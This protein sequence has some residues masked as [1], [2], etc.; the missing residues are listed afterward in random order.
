[1]TFQKYKESLLKLAFF[2]MS[3]LLLFPSNI[4]PLVI[5]VFAIVM[6]GFIYFEKLKFDVKYFTING[7]IYLLL[8]LSLVYTDDI[9]YSFKKFESMSSL[10]IFPFLFSFLS[11]F[12]LKI[13][14]NINRFLFY[15]ILSVAL[16]NITF[17]L[18]I[19][20]GGDATFKN[21][22]RHYVFLIDNGLG[23]YNIHPIY[24]SMHLC[25]AIIFCMYLITKKTS[26]KL[27]SP[28]ILILGILFFFLFL[29][30]KKGPIISLALVTVVYF[31]IKTK[32]KHKVFF[33][34]SMIVFFSLIFSSQTS[35]DHFYEILNVK[36]I[37]E[38]EMSSSNI[39]YTI[40]KC[41][42]NLFKKEPL[43]GYGVGDSNNELIKS[44]K[45]VSSKLFYDKYNTHNQYLSFLLRVGLIGLIFILASF[46]F[47]FRKEIKN[48][49]YLFLMVFCFYLLEMFTENIL[50][51]QDGVIFYSFFVALLQGY[52]K[53]EIEV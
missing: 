32:M 25:I 6:I 45:D 43:L 4:K 52:N 29:L 26:V 9:A 34:L 8:I 18:M 2:L 14:K 42:F 35:R 24:M 53:S 51:R 31:F 28:L 22:M 39:R 20:L 49:N 46:F 17:F 3:I 5:G 15:F 10:F 11:K 44:Y 19:W 30:S 50:E 47:L 48:S 21:V 33:L 12:P 1:M 41:S 13:F 36:D 38:G 37:R 40:Y 7:A 27:I 23:N 16:L